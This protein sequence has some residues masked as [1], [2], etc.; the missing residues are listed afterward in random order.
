MVLRKG[1]CLHE[2]SPTPDSSKLE[3]TRYIRQEILD[4]VKRWQGILSVN[5]SNYNQEN[6]AL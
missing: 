4:E 6:N 1:K 2:N 3:Y 5:Y